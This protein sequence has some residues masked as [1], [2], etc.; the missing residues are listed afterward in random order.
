M[1]AH[2]DVTVDATMTPLPMEQAPAV[3]NYESAALEEEVLTANEDTIGDEGPATKNHEESVLLGNRAVHPLGGEELAIGPHHRGDPAN[4]IDVDL[5]AA[6]REPIDSEAN[7]SPATG[8]LDN[9]CTAA[10]SLEVPVEEDARITTVSSAG[11]LTVEG[12][13]VSAL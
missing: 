4:S 6:D 12:S 8:E 13:D 1:H 5:V 2:D 9:A 11:T 10:L 3:H 7:T